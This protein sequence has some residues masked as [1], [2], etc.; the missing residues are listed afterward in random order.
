MKKLIL[1]VIVAL[2]T[3][4]VT[5]KQEDK[6]YEPIVLTTIVELENRKKLELERKII[7]FSATEMSAFQ[8]AYNTL[9]EREKQL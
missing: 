5:D 9:G 8:N 7:D 1:F 4:C 2:L 6:A 3:G